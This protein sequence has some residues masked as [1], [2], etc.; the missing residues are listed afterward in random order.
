[1]RQT[2]HKLLSTAAAVC[3]IFG[4][5]TSVFA[6]SEFAGSLNT[7]SISDAA[8]TNTP[9]T[10]SFTYTQ[11]GD[12]FTFDASGSFDSDG[13]ITEY[14]WDFGDGTVGT[15][16]T[17]NFQ[18]ELATSFFATLT[19]V[20]N[21]GGVAIY[22]QPIQTTGGTAFYWSMDTLPSPTM[23]SDTGDISISLYKTAASSVPGISGNAMQQ[24]GTWNSYSFPATVLPT[25]KGKIE[26]YVKH[27]FGP[28]TSDATNRTIFRTSN[29]GKANSIYAYTYKNIMFFYVY[30]SSGVYHRAYKVADT[31]EVGSWYKYEFSWDSDN[32]YLGIKRDGTV[33]AESTAS[34]WTALSLDTQD[35]Y[36]GYIYPIGSF[37]E[38]SIT[39]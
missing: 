31:W 23:T 17:A 21:A 6:Q 8:G 11:D 4:T 30:D 25:T 27:D 28:N 26:I 7:V 35:M 5:S 18:N 15:G 32:G 33:V 13:S 20:D 19:A 14:K 38:L 36:I 2:T 12:T 37:D 34:P 22:R 39:N 1:M 16:V 3:L 24:E 29:E 9:P 10:A